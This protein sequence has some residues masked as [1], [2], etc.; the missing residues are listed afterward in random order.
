MRW[1][2][3]LLVTASLTGCADPGEEETPV[4]VI[5]PESAKRDDPVYTFV[6]YGTPLVE[7]DSQDL[8]IRLFV[9]GDA[10][11]D[12]I[13]EWTAEPGDSKQ[14]LAIYQVHEPVV[15]FDAHADGEFA[16]GAN[17]DLSTCPNRDGD[18]DFRVKDNSVR[19]HHNVEINYGCSS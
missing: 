1:I 2:V 16:G 8:D 11:P 17:L 10:F 13:V 4:L 6:L 9:G 14:A 15:H 12:H 5:K 3:L 7:D 18:A 19:W